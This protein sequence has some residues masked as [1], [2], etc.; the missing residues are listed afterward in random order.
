MNYYWSSIAVSI[1]YAEGDPSPSPKKK[2]IV[3]LV[4]Y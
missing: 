2:S 3:Y 1:K 4:C